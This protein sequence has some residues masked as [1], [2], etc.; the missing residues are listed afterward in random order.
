MNEDLFVGTWSLVSFEVRSTNGTVSYPF[1]RDVRGYITYSQD[2]YMSVSFMGVDRP[3][4]KSNDLR[5][6]S[7]E[8]KVLAFD[9][10]FTYCGKYEVT[11][12]KVVHHIEVSF[13]PNWVGEDQERFYAFDGG[14][15]ILTTPP[16]LIDN[17][18]QTAYLIWKRA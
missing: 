4:F 12:K 15:L 5:G 18:E 17:S 10:Y 7:V 1:G 16:L 14:Q 13:Y 2:G 9:T 3:H 6:A 8:E 11:D